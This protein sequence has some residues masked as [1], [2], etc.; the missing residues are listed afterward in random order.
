[1]R[2]PI[3]LAVS[4]LAAACQTESRVGK[5]AA[6]VASDTDVL[7]EANAA[8]NAVVRAAGDC[9]AVKAGLDAARQSLDDAEARVSTTTGKAT[10]EAMRKRLEGI[11]E[12]C[13]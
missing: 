9:E 4:L 3:T 8:A 2:F 6:N 1:V 12:T 7:R 10:L 11:A 13:P 5:D